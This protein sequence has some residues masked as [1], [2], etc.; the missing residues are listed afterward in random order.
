MFYRSQIVLAVFFLLVSVTGCKSA[1]QEGSVQAE[2]KPAPAQS[3]QAPI[4]AA[5]PVID[6]KGKVLETMDV[7]GYTY[8]QVDDDQGPAWVAIPQT[9]VEKG[10]EVSVTTGMEMLN[11]ESKTLGR[12]FDSIIFAGG[13]DGGK[14]AASG[15]SSAAAPVAGGAAGGGS[16][17]E[18]LQAEGSAGG[19]AV[20][21]PGQQTGGSQAAIAPAS[22]VKVEKAE[23]ENA[24]TV[25]E[26]FAKSKDLDKKKIR[27]KGKVV[28]VSPMIM[29]K[30]WLHIQD[31]T[32]DA[33]K[34]THD[35]VVTTMAQPEKDSVVVVEG[36]LNKDRD[37]GAGYKY[38]VII[39]DAEIK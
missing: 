1:D 35:L 29:G 10:Q 12:T 3:G 37:F 20:M 19:T 34:K 32:G 6:I 18:A 16:F 28:K 15:P 4:Q 17:S 9:K 31:G 7:G 33:A 38:N 13:I 21:S 24:Y 39:E 11:F 23:G 14:T 36:T 25:G 27:V 26:L 30:N 2:K 5:K 22:E 8:L